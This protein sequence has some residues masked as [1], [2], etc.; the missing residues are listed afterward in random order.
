[1]SETENST[2]T[3]DN[4]KKSSD[5]SSRIITPFS[6]PDAQT[7]TSSSDSSGGGE[8]RQQQVIT[9]LGDRQPGETIIDLGD[10]TPREISIKPAREPPN[11]FYTIKSDSR[12][13]SK[14]SIQ[15]EQELRRE[16]MIDSIKESLRAN[17]SGAEVIRDLDIDMSGAAIAELVR[18]ARSRLEMERAEH[19]QIIEDRQAE[20]QRRLEASR[21][22]CPY[23]GAICGWT[24]ES[25]SN[26]LK[27]CGKYH[28]H[29]KI[30]QEKMQRR[31]NFVGRY[32]R[33][34]DFDISRSSGSVVDVV[35]TINNLRWTEN[36]AK[37][38]SGTK[39]EAII[40][41]MQ[42]IKERIRSESDYDRRRR[43]KQIAN[44][45]NA[46]TVIEGLYRRLEEEEQD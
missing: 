12:R 32:E 17:R 30:E 34:L 28:E 44:L 41:G 3:K 9:P 19:Q 18:E 27:I 7:T 35:D 4:I 38:S 26:H 2:S 39:D 25:E 29:K 31:K 24:D 11:K 6:P 43:Q 8:G 5:Y 15:K 10:R 33:L 22:V 1:M 14:E 21:F 37:Y 46:A 40:E 36:E 23:C 16:A 45:R 20:F 13:R 42:R